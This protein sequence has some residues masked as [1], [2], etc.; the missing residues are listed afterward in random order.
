MK[1]VKMTQAQK[2][3]NVP[4]FGVIC[5]TFYLVL[6]TLQQHHARFIAVPRSNPVQRK[7]SILLLSPKRRHLALEKGQNCASKH[8]VAGVMLVREF[9]GPC[10]SNWIEKVRKNKSPS[11][12]QKPSQRGHWHWSITHRSSLRR[13]QCHCPNVTPYWNICNLFP[14]FL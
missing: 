10:T 8:A 3:V 2:H 6:L 4:F 9:R 7:C 11:W 1:L 13:M 12:N 5:I 14:P